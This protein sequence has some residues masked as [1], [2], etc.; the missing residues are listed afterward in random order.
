MKVID[1]KYFIKTGLNVVLKIQWQRQQLFRNHQT[2]R[3]VGTL[4]Y[5]SWVLHCCLNLLVFVLPRHLRGIVV[6][7]KS[8]VCCKQSRRWSRCLTSWWERGRANSSL[9]SVTRKPIPSPLTTGPGTKARWSFTVS[10]IHCSAFTTYHFR[11]LQISPHLF[12][13]HLDTFE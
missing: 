12:P 7:S 5:T 2:F 3:L 6:L 11:S 9:W 4:Y 10:A 1:T 8:A 13:V